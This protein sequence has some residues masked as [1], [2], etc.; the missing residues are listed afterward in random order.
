MSIHDHTKFGNHFV[1]L[2]CNRLELCALFFIYF[3]NLGGGLDAGHVNSEDCSKFVNYGNLKNW[4]EKEV[5]EDIRDRFTTGDWSK[6]ALRNKNSVA[7]DE[8]E[9]DELYG[10]FEDLETGEKHNDHENMESGTNEDVEAAERR[11]KKLALRAKFDAQYPFSLQCHHLSILS[12][13]SFAVIHI[14][15]RPKNYI[16]HLHVFYLSYMVL[17]F[18]FSLHIEKLPFLFNLNFIVQAINRS[19]RM[20]TMIMVMG[21]IPVIVR[22]R[23]PDSLTK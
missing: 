19:W 12:T 20:M 8:G 3:Q 9:D 13:I 15:V 1:F 23:N 11:L 6:A 4:K 7:G 5:C 14:C 18:C 2:E 17:C 10:D 22:P 21:S 16:L